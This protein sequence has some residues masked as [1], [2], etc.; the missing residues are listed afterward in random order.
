M[1]TTSPSEI[2]VMCT[3]LAM[4]GLWGTTLYQYWPSP[5]TRLIGQKQIHQA[6]CVVCAYVGDS[7]MIICHNQRVAWMAWRRERQ[8]VPCSFCYYNSI[9]I[10]YIAT[11]YFI[12]IT[13]LH[14]KCSYIY[15]YIYTYIYT[16]LC[17]YI[18]TIFG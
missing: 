17:L 18:R 4:Y 11:I 5:W 12:S 2:G 14:V 15:I 3:N 13:M 7:R 16:I 1:S 9:F 8:L 10:I 6:G